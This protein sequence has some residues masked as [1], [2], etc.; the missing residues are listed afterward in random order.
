MKNV[1]ELIIGTNYLTFE[2][3]LIRYD[4][5]PMPQLLFKIM[6]TKRVHERHETMHNSFLPG[7]NLFYF[8]FTSG[9]KFNKENDI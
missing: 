2:I 1:H 7:M 9:G 5:S 3:C 6:E 4:V 8:I